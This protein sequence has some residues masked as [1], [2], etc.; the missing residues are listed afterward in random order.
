MTKN[1]IT[2]IGTN[3]AVAPLLNEL[4]KTNTVHA[5][6][7]APLSS[8]VP[9]VELTVLPPGPLFLDTL[10]KKYNKETSPPFYLR[11]L[12]P[13]LWKTN[14]ET[15]I[16]MD[17]FRFWSLQAYIYA[18]L[19]KGTH[20]SI[21]SET[22]RVPKSFMSRIVFYFMLGILQIISFKITRIIVYEELGF[23]FFKKRGFKKVDIIKLPIDETLF[24]PSEEKSYKDNNVLRLIMVA[25]YAT[26]K[27]H[28]DLLKALKQCVETGLNNIHITLI[29]STG[30]GEKAI[31]KYT[32]DAELTPHITILPPVQKEQLRE[33]YYKHDV[34]VLP[35]EYEAIGMV[36]PEAMACGLATI[37]SDTVG[38]NIYVED[39]ETGL[40]FETGNIESL[41]KKIKM[42][43]ESNLAEKHG[44]SGSKRMAELFSKQNCAES[45]TQ[46]IK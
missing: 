11:G 5:Y 9:E 24:Y 40:V 41:H 39:N 2:F 20:I 32:E 12:I 45:F 7:S 35:S 27:R 18:L 17:I 10:L 33:V 38:A 25:R 44:I 14:P 15:I 16:V 46:L 6:N 42:Y 34:L 3:H 28:I 19:H 1:T 37:T 8:L 29:G 4:S 31:M 23:E 13:L 26:Y 22:K 21:L 36:I 30:N 43:A